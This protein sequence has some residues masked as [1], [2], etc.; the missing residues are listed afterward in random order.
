MRARALIAGLA[1]VLLAGAPAAGA[2]APLVPLIAA[3]RLTPLSPVV[4]PPLALPRL[5][6]GRTL[7]L[8]DFRGRPVLVYFWATW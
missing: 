1:L 2:G 4:P 8:A 6:D 3:L 7:E 5:D